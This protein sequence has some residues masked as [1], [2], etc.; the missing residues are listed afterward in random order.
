[1]LTIPSGAIAVSYTTEAGMN[2]GD[3]CANFAAACKDATGVLFQTAGGT[4]ISNKYISAISNE[5]V[6]LSAFSIT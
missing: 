5:S 6:V 3:V 1:M 4:D 2:L